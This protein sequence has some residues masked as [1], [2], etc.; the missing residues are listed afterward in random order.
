M[1]S[2]GSAGLIVYH[3]LYDYLRGDLVYMGFEF[4]LETAENRVACMH[5][6][7]QIVHEFKHGRLQG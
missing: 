2:V 3:N 1:S 7:D 6:L 5:N 4:S